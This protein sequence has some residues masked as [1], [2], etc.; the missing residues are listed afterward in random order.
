VKRV[1]GYRRLFPKWASSH[2]SRNHFRGRGR[3]ISRAR[4]HRFEYKKTVS[5]EHN[6]E[7]NT[8]I[9]TIC[10]SPIQAQARLNPMEKEGRD[11]IPL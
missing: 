8:E 3:D 2:G 4:S 1:R 6:V 10:T 11:E 9:V 7:M 5:S